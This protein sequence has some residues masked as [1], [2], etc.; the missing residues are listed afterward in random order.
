MSKKLSGKSIC[1]AIPRKQEN[2]N[3]E[4]SG[5][6]DQIS[7]FFWFLW[8]VFCL[9]RSR[10]LQIKGNGPITSK[11]PHE[12]RC[13]VLF[14]LQISPKSWKSLP[15]IK[16]YIKSLFSGGYTYIYLLD[17]L[18]FQIYHGFIFH[19]TRKDRSA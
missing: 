7:S 4:C 11:L 2:E 3:Q 10:K 1:H 12:V 19:S 15:Y 13:K 8:I 14:E 17:Q 9:I 5:N 16:S 18:H 6:K